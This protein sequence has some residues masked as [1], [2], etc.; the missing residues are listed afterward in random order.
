MSRSFA[1]KM[2]Q[3]G[4]ILKNNA[5]ELVTMNDRDNT[6]CILNDALKIICVIIIE[7]LTLVAILRYPG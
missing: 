6:Q 3:D 7:V 1:S 2:S 4:I 5:S